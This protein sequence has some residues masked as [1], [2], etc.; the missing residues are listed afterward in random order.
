MSRHRAQDRRGLLRGW[1]RL[2]RV[3]LLITLT[4]VVYL[5]WW[6]GW[7]L[8]VQPNVTMNA[9]SELE[10]IVRDAQPPGENGWAL[11]DKAHAR[12]DRVEIALDQLTRPPLHANRTNYSILFEDSQDKWLL[13]NDSDYEEAV[14]FAQIA[15]EYFRDED[16]VTP[17]LK[18]RT[19]ANI[20]KTDYRIHEATQ[21]QPLFRVLL[22]PRLTVDQSLAAALRADMHDAFR[23]GDTHR[24]LRA[25]EA[26]F[27]LGHAIAL[28][29]TLIQ[30]LIGVTIHY[31]AFTELI[32]YAN[33]HTVS[34]DCARD[35]I[36]LLASIDMASALHT[37]LDGE[38]VFFH[39]LIQFLYSD[40]GNND[41]VMLFSE[42][43]KH[44]I[45]VS[46]NPRTQTYHPRLLNLAG[47]LF[48]SRKDM[49]QRIDD[50]HARLLVMA[51]LPYP[52]AR[53]MINAAEANIVDDWRFSLYRV[54]RP[55]GSGLLYNQAYHR[56]LRYGVQLLYA[57]EGFQSEHGRL[58]QSLDELEESWLS[59]VPVDPFSGSP[60]IYRLLDVPD[61]HGRMYMLYSVFQDG[62]D[63]GGLPRG[64]NN[65]TT[66]LL[67]TLP[68]DRPPTATQTP[69][70]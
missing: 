33:R 69:G 58:P 21:P 65:D 38:H 35:V 53:R 32:A 27:S 56:A 43:N 39:E 14:A 34:Q 20:V 67:F 64:P 25:A 1:L 40:D 63:D 47:T 57:I 60:F 68:D 4:C 49:I 24:A 12:F 51:E 70:R 41:G 15:L 19:A 42:L 54:N 62:E 11:I 59:P 44:G 30:Y 31:M 46:G 37:S 36:A 10:Q 22:F 3:A 61:K 29:P 45:S 9:M 55:G 23:T 5:G 26:I 6:V 52:D 66:D 16:I 8:T 48:A 2:R 50:E 28:Q 17:L 18:A 13:A 7:A